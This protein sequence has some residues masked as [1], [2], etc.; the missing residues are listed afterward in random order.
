MFSF[1]EN[2]KRKY[3]GFEDIKYIINNNKFLLINTL[4]SNNQNLLIKNTTH[5]DQEE[6]IINDLISDY[7]TPD[8]SI[9]I[10]GKNSCD[11]TVIEK[12]DQLYKLGLR[13]LYIYGGGL[14]EW[15][16]LNEIQVLTSQIDA[17]TLIH[18]TYENFTIN[19]ILKYREPLILH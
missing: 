7:K 15:L 8:K 10:Y 17:Q 18:L 4:H 19:D 13:E 6:K 14:F 2:Q 12:Y 1:F 5:I 11:M 3:V 9:I 16:L